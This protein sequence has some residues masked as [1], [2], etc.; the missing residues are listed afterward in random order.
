MV[1]SDGSVLMP[2]SRPCY[3][4]RS[5]AGADQR[6]FALCL[7]GTE[8]TLDAHV[9]S[10]GES[11]RA[12]LV[13]AVDRV[14]SGDVLVLDRGYSAAWLVALLSTRGIRFVMRCDDASGWTADKTFLRSGVDEAR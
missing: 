8:L 5:A 10:A 12:Q 4:V 14:A 9:C 7:P 3:R 2:V 13:D 6:L 1:A 11:E